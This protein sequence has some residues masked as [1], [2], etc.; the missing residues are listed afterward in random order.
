MP[1]IE[2]QGTVSVPYTKKYPRVIGGQ[3]EFHGVMDKTKSA[4]VQYT[5]C[6][7]FKDIGLLRCSYCDESRNPNEVIYSSTI[8]IHGSPT[9]PNELVA[10]CDSFECSQKH[11]ARFKLSK[12]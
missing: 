4:E 12:S 2:R 8:N 7:H 6:S 10:V 3:C 5:L 9:N 1:T 11:L